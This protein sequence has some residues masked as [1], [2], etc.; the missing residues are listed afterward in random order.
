MPV[1]IIKNQNIDKNNNTG[2]NMKITQKQLIEELQDKIIDLKTDLEIVVDQ[3]FSAEDLNKLKELTERN[4]PQEWEEFKF[5]TGEGRRVKNVS[6][7]EKRK[8]LL[9]Y[10]DD[11]FTPG[12]SRHDKIIYDTI[13]MISEYLE[14]N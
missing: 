8:T 12:L 4:F 14:E 3:I 9:E 7:F 13:K 6:C 1:C 10:A 2:I 5:C 11:N